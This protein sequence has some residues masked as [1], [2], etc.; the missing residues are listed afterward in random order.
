MSKDH[1]P[2]SPPHTTLYDSQQAHHYVK[3]ENSLSNSECRGEEL[4]DNPAKLRQSLK[5]YSRLVC[6]MLA[7][8]AAILY[9]GYDSAILGLL[10]GVPAYQQDFGDWM[11]HHDGTSHYRWTIPALWLALW[12]GT[13]PLGQ[14]AG[15]VL[16]GWLLDR[17]GR[18]LCLRLGCM[19]AACATLILFWANAPTNKL[20]RR[21]MILV[22]KLIQGL[23]I[24][25]IKVETITYMSEIIPVCLK[26]ALLALLPIFGLVGYLCGIVV[27][28]A[29][30]NQSSLSYKTALAAQWAFA[31]AP[32]FLSFFMPESPAF[33]LKNGNSHAALHSF[34][35]L[36]GPKNDSSLAVTQM[37]KNLKREAKNSSQG[38]YAECINAS[39][40]RR[41]LIV[42]F[43]SNIEFVMGLS[44]LFTCSYFLQ[45]LGMQ[46]RESMLFIVGIVVT[47]LVANVCSAWTVSHI[48]RRKLSIATLLVASGLWGTMGFSGINQTSTTPWFCG[49]LGISITACCGIGCWPVAVA[50]LGETSSLRLRSKSQAIGSLS[51]HLS[52]FAMDFMLPYMYNPD[53]ANS[54]AKIGFLFMGLTCVGA[55]VTY[56]YVPELKDRS[57]TEVD[58]FFSEGI[59]ARDSNRWQRGRMSMSSC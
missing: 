57:A 9:T 1:A 40:R 13:C 36:L 44:F 5:Q 26:G 3:S 24:G 6:W 47:G 54:G 48:G 41:T 4:E 25:M 32:L 45:Q 56:L 15:A 49:G 8:S 12:D 14:M 37:E 16:G 7:M 21:L 29:S 30:K 19:I 28:F 20:D 43:A 34:E 33:L 55:I 46:Y 38:T 18:K 50:V 17:K 2:Q 52:S 35:R 59:R 11:E 27:Y 58:G 51:H 31:L 39:N 53:A 23:G 22:G 10:K 42:V